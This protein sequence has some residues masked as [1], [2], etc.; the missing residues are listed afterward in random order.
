MLSSG[1]FPHGH[2][3]RRAAAKERLDVLMVVAKAE[4]GY[5]RDAEAWLSSHVFT[6]PSGHLYIV[7]SC[8]CPTQ[9]AICPECRCYVGGSDHILGPGNRLAHGEVA[10]LRAEAG[11]K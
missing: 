8:G 1:R 6:C 9:S 11:G 5:G 7:G 3:S 2:Q 4:C 10:Q